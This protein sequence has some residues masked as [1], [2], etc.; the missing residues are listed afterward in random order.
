[1]EEDCGET[2]T[3]MGRHHK[4]RLLDAAECK[5]TGEINREQGY[6]EANTEEV[7]AS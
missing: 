7:Q 1:M 4:K 3:E 5:A 6:M 2:T